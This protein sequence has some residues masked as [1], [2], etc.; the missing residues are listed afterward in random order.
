MK[1]YLK[2]VALSEV[3]LYI[4]EYVQMTIS[5]EKWLY[6][7]LDT[8]HGAPVLPVIV[9][10]VGQGAGPGLPRVPPMNQDH[11]PIHLLF[12]EGVAAGEGEV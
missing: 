8:T 2:E 4:C 9:H 10:G 12:I 11:L 5:L 3:L 1:Q 6:S 7:P